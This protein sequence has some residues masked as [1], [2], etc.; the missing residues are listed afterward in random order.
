MSLV[1]QGVIDQAGDAL[2]KAVETLNGCI[3]RIVQSIK[4]DPQYDRDL[5]V[6]LTWLTHEVI[7]IVAELRLLDAGP[8]PAKG[9]GAKSSLAD[10]FRTTS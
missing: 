1:D 5:V 9:G 4:E 3:D 6:H 10:R 7:R 2:R 8:A